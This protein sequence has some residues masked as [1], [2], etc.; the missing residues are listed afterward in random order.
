MGAHLHTPRADPE[1]VRALAS[2]LPDIPRWV[3]ARDLLLAGECEIFGLSETPELSLVLR[4]AP[5]EAFFVV[6][7]PAVTAIQAAVRRSTR[8]GQVIAVP[9]QANLVAAALPGWIRTRAILH[10]LLDPGR[11]PP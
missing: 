8:G 1:S 3:E 2:R 7:Q 9:E 5:T 11:L 6:G 10:L 4:D